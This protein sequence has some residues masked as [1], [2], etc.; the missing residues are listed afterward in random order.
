MIYY[1]NPRH[2]V[3]RFLAL[4]RLGNQYIVTCDTCGLEAKPVK[5]GRFKWWAESRAYRAFFKLANK[6]DEEP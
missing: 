3:H 6:L 2:C 1:V 4:H 5:V